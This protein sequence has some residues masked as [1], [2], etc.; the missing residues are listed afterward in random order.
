ML[1]V[2]LSTKDFENLSQAR[3]YDVPEC[4][5]RCPVSCL[6]LYLSKIKPDCNLLFPIPLK[7]YRDQTFWYCEKRSLGV[8]SIGSLWRS[9]LKRQSSK[10]Y[11]NHCLRTGNCRLD[12][13]WQWVT[14]KWYR[15][16]DRTQKCSE[17]GKICQAQEGWRE[18]KIFTDAEQITAICRRN[19]I[20]FSDNNNFD[21]SNKW[22]YST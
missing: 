8:N 21:N 6:R 5:N 13:A 7:K 15:G 2:S 1:R 11:T 20:F 17:C 19:E 10:R 9:F 3:I 4:P 22:N 16:S 14:I 18:T 12:P